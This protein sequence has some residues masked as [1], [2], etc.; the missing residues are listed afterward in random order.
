VGLLRRYWTACCRTSRCGRRP[1]SPRPGGCSGACGRKLLLATGGFVALP[2]A[3]AARA[4]Q[5]PGGRPRADSA[6]GLANRVAG[7]FARRIA[8]TFR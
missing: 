5:H 7:R 4:L 2:P 6:P 8:L 3:L 1:V